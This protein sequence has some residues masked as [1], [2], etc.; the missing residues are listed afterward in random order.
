M[1]HVICK[2]HVRVSGRGDVYV[3]DRDR[4]PHLIVGDVI[5]TSLT[6]RP[7]RIVA[8]ELTCNG[9]GIK[10]EMGLVLKT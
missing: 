3:A 4:N 6:E 5:T 9:R 2:Y 10:N 7:Q 1:N 8:I